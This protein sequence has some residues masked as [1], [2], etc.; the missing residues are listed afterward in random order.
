MAAGPAVSGTMTLC[1]QS[2][3]S[4]STDVCFDVIGIQTVKEFSADIEPSIR[5]MVCR[6][7]AQARR[8]EHSAKTGP[9]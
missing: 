4:P 2:G 1:R 9:E 7:A 5:R 6:G 3:E 8:S